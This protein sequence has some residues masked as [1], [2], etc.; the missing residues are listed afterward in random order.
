MSKHKFYFETEGVGVYVDNIM[1]W[2]RKR[3]LHVD[4]SNM[5]SALDV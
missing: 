3:G 1:I 4:K 2:E 5:G